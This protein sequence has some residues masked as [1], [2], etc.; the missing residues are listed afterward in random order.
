MKRLNPAVKFVCL[1]VLTF[2]LAFRHQPILNFAFFALCIV[3][4]LSSG[5][6]VKKLLILLSPI[7]LAAAGMFFTGYRFSAGEG[8]PVNSNDMILTGSHVWNGLIHASRVLAF[9][10]GGYLY[11]LTTDR[12]L[13]IRSFQRQF[14]L[15]QIFAYGL[16]AAWGVFPHM[17]QEYRR[18]RAAFRARGKNP[19]PVSPAFLKPLLVK[20]VRWSEALAVAMESKGFDGHEARSDFEP[21]RVRWFDGLFCAVCAA[22][23]VV[24]LAAF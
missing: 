11:C 23:C 13:M 20:S 14:H 3:G 4:I 1:M 22:L 5:T 15:P 18:T 7:L 12:V 6:D 16:L 10:G 8:M 24:M 21:V 9:A 2:V 17:M 19:F